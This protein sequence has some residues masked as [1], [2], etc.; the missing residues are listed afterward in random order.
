MFC[1]ANK[2]TVSFFEVIA[3]VTITVALEVMY[4]S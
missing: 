1:K 2:R 3:Y 4:M